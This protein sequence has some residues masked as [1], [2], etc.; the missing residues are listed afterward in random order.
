[1]C[2]SLSIIYSFVSLSLFR[3]EL[4]QADAS[5]PGGCTMTTIGSSCEVYMQ[6][7]GLVDIAKEVARLEESIE[8]RSTQRAK[9]IEVTEAEG[10]E[11][12]VWIVWALEWKVFPLYFLG[13]KRSENSQPREGI[14]NSLVMAKLLLWCLVLQIQSLDAEIENLTCALK[15]FKAL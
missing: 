5:P 11:E 9:L 15:E 1:M 8:K 7:K 14:L 6:L 3:V 13:S 4:L 12:K 2:L 10:Y